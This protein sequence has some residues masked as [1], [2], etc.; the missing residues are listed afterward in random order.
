MRLYTRSRERRPDPPPMTTNERSLVWT[1]TAVWLVL[2][3]LAA[4][5]YG[6]LAADGRGWWLW[7]PVIGVLLGLLGI[8][9]LAGKGR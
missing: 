9:W 8:R 2:G 5:G 3:V 4:V 7:T 6:R 1:V